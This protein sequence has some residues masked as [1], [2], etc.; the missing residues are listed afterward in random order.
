MS[1]EEAIKQFSS[2]SYAMREDFGKERSLVI[3]EFSQFSH[4]SQQN[5]NILLWFVAKCSIGLNVKP[6]DVIDGMLSPENE[7][8]IIN[9][10]V[11]EIELRAFTEMWI[12]DGRCR[13]SRK[14]Y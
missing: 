3:P 6:Q 13:H 14:P 12:N 10:Q 1:I 8:E 2:Q 5:Q 11:S 4:S 7:Q 9:G